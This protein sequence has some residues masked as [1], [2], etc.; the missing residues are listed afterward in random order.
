MFPSWWRHLVKLVSPRR[1]PKRWHRRT[2]PSLFRRP[3]LEPLEDRI[4]PTQLSIPTNLVGEQGGIVTVPINVDTLNDGDGHKGLSGGQLVVFYNP[5]VFSVSG[6]DVGLGS[7]LSPGGWNIL[8]DT[9][10]PGYLLIDL[11]VG[12]LITST[13]GGTLVTVNFHVF[14]NAP[15]GPSLIDL[16]A[17]AGS[18]PDGSGASTY[19]I[20]ENA[21]VYGDAYVLTPSPIDNVTSLSPFTYVGTDPDDSTVAVVPPA[22]NTAVST[23]LSVTPLSSTFT[24]GQPTGFLVVALNNNEDTASGFTGDVSFSSSDSR[25][26]LPS[27]SSVASGI[28]FFSAT[29]ATAGAQTITATVVL[30]PS[31]SG[32]SNAITV[33]AGLTTHFVVTQPTT[34]QAGLPFSLLVTTEDSSNN[35]TSSFS[36]TIQFSSSDSQAVL[37]PNASLTNGVG[38]FS[39]TL[40]TVV[41]KH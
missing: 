8:T 10:T 31:I 25:A 13:G 37:P 14:N 28:G 39:A 27:P 20:A 40:M 22:V 34:V 6:S 15:L 19:L 12:N 17:N 11:D 4:V 30:S 33:T 7:L 36:G 23:H 41:R 3:A 16:A 18:G 21:N 1:E 24:A 32:S 38:T 29:L 2:A 9:V 35:T 26:I 5:A